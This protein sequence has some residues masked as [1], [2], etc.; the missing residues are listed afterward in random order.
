MKQSAIFKTLHLVALLPVLTTSVLPILEPQSLNARA[1]GSEGY[2][3]WAVLSMLFVC[4]VIGLIDFVANVCGN[5]NRLPILA[6]YRPLGMIAISF[7]MLTN[8]VVLYMYMGGSFLVMR[9][10]EQTCPPLAVACFLWLDEK[11]IHRNAFNRAC[12]ELLRGK[13]CCN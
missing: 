4:V 7:L 9:F 13:R 11:E 8:S 6:K 5:E 10:I 1:L 3:G 2:A 12:K